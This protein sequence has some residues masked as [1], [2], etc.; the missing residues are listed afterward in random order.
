MKNADFQKF[1]KAAN[2]DDPEDLIPFGITAEELE[3]ELAKRAAAKS[4][5]AGQT[6][7]R[8]CERANRNG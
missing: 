5:L 8:I 2:D 7:Q 4:K 6:P 1:L 3:V